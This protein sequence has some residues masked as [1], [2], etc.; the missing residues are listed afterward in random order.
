MPLKY[1]ADQHREYLDMVERVGVR[2]MDMLRGDVKFDSAAYWD[3]LT[4]MWR[5]ELP[6][7]KTDALGFM[8]G[9]RSAHTAGKYL[10]AAIRDGIILESDNPEDGR[11]RL[12]TLSPAMRRRLDA[13]FDAAVEE[14]R[15]SVRRIDDKAIRPHREQVE[16]T[17]GARLQAHGTR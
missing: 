6:V 13:F 3:L 5:A 15:R 11:S 9:V 10:D 1:E 16:K 14:V 7:R 12:L 8:R 4:R 17:D 2:W